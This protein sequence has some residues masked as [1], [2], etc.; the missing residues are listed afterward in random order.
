MATDKPISVLT[1]ESDPLDT[2]FM[3]IVDPAAPIA[4]R[5]KQILVPNLRA[6]KIRFSETAHGFSELDAVG[7]D[8]VNWVKSQAGVQAADGIVL[9]IDDANTFVLGLPGPHTKTAHG[10]TL[11]QKW[12]SSTVAGGLADAVTVGKPTQRIL[13][14]IDSNT[15]LVQ[16]GDYVE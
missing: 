10:L 9:L 13:K 2:W 7:H 11:V 1:P 4:D 14:P 12:L 3:E 5:N 8:G 15:L 6:P 16:I